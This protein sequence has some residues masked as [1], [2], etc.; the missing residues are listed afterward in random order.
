VPKISAAQEQRRRDQIL[1][2]SFACFARQ[3]YRATSMEDIVR[4][5]GLSVG[6]IYTYFAS[7]EDLFLALA[8]RHTEQTLQYLNDVFRRPGPMA[9]KSR[10]AVEYFFRNLSD[11]FSPIARIGR[12]FWS[13]APKSERLMER[14]GEHCARIR[15]FYHWL[16]EEGQ[17][18]GNLRPEVDV[19]AAAELLMALN[20]GVM[21]LHVAGIRTASLDALKSAYVA[22]LN[23]GLANAER[24]FV[25]APDPDRDLAAATAGA[26]AASIRH[27]EI[28]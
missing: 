24:A 2:A 21:T 7:K 22:L 18:A 28:A 23:Q 8:D 3:G 17:R 16:M 20:E 14:F 26:P 27:Q 5:S 12:E 4:E 11:D 1:N 15:Q 9:E 19:T 25:A 13:E 10:E 6:A